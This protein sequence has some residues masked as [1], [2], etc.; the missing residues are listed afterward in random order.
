MNKESND[1][2]LKKRFAKIPPVEDNSDKDTTI[3]TTK[4][5]IKET[6]DIPQSNSNL[7][8]LYDIAEEEKLNFII[9]H[10]SPNKYSFSS[11]LVPP[12]VPKVDQKEQKD[13]FDMIDTSDES[14]E[15][16]F[17]LRFNETSTHIAAGYSTGRICIF[18]ISQL[19][20]KKSLPVLST[21]TEFPITCIR[22]KPHNRTTLLCV[23]A[24]GTIHQ[25]HST[26][27][28]I[29]FKTEENGNPLMCCDYSNDGFLFATGGNDKKV[30]LYDDNTKTMISKLESHQYNLPEHSNRIFSVKFHPND[31]NVLLSGGWDNNI[32]IYDTRAKEVC[33]SLYGP[34]ICGDAIDIK[35]DTILTAS[36]E[37]RDQIQ[38]WD[39][40][41]R[42]SISVIQCKYDTESENHNISTYLYSCRFHPKKDLFVVSGS[43]K[44]LIRGYRYKDIKRIEE[45]ST[46]VDFECNKMILPCY[47]VDFSYE[48]SLMAYASADSMIRLVNLK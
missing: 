29:L 17:T 39:L 44:N 47:S 1:D 22:W 31:P 40:K 11:F 23:S 26:S 2:I 33:G 14:N 16:C 48:G 13:A 7:K 42:K 20:S 43:N 6:N 32:L 19:Q 46:E 35:G 5:T 21:L 4:D 38:I 3:D 10:S 45:S 25:V 34:H 9:S 15:E 8:S 36:W 27:G 28:K 37:K 12:I 24:E 41:M 30:R 18:P